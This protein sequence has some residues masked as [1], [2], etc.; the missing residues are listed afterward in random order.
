MEMMLVTFVVMLVLV[1]AMAI[2]VIMGRDPIKGSCGGMS[3]L[4]LETAC[5]IC[6][7][8]PAKCDEENQRPGT[9]TQESI[10]K[11]SIGQFY[12]AAK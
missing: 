10:T 3:A 11:N 7:G 12:D 8:N 5:D 2:G 6:G 1:S 9:V 4:G